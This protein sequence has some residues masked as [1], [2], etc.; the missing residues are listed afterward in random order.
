MFILINPA[1][2]YA[3]WTTKVETLSD[4]IATKQSEVDAA[5]QGQGGNTGL[6]RQALAALQAALGHARDCATF[7]KDQTKENQQATAKTFDLA[8]AANA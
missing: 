5:V 1:F 2:E 7:W 8:K 6:L 3:K 4:Q